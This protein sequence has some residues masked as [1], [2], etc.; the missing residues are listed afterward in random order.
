MIK[1]IEILGIQL[2]NYTVQEAMGR[3][4]EFLNSTAMHTIEDISMEMLVKAGEDEALR[5]CIES[6]DLA[7]ISEQEILKTAGVSSQQ[8]L[9]ETAEQQ[10][11]TEFLRRAMGENRTACLLADTEQR[12]ERL[13]DF[14]R[15]NYGELRI[16]AGFALENC[17]G[18]VEGV[19][20]DINGASPDIVFSVLPVPEQEYFLMEQQSKLN[21]SVWYGMGSGYAS[22]HGVSKMKRMAK[23]LLHRGMMKRMVSRYK[24][25]KGKGADGADS[26]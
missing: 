20:N 19:V 24:Q 25:E 17:V 21:V 10:F 7:V 2:D 13:Q 15:E 26:K 23:R 3:V 18:D 11:F 16:L 4:D 8:R 1:K 6:L 14:F 9:R 12:L 5:D 22:V